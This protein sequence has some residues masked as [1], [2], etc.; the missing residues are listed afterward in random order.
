MS[1]RVRLER[2]RT[3]P[4]CFFAA[5]AYTDSPEPMPPCEG[6]LVR[7]HLIPQQLLR[8]TPQYQAITLRPMRH[9]FLYDER[10]WVWGC[11]GAMGIGGHHHMFDCSKRIR[12]ARCSIP[13][14]T[15]ELA[16]ALDL[17]WYL[18]RTFGTRACIVP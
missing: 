9:W 18:D 1:V 12:L 6:P 8:R 4:T 2:P 15:E 14:G 16:E 7:C 13:A 17:Q 5:H 10:S 11:G 3:R